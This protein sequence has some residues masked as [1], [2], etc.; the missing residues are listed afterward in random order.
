MNKN[1]ENISGFEI[2]AFSNCG[3]PLKLAKVTSP[4]LDCTYIHV[5]EVPHVYA[6]CTQSGTSTFTTFFH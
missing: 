3:I 4:R 1:I 2:M 6:L 5:H